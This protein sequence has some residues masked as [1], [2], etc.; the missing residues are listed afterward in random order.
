VVRQPILASLSIVAAL[1][2]APCGA[3]AAAQPIPLGGEIQLDLDSVDQ[4]PTCPL[5]AGRDDGRFLFLYG[6]PRTPTRTSV[7]A[8]AGASD[9]SLGPAVVLDYFGSDTGNGLVA[10]PGGYL[11][12]WSNRLGAIA[13]PFDVAGSP[14]GAPAAFGRWRNPFSL[15]PRPTGGFVATWTGSN[16]IGNAQLL[17]AQARPVRGPVRFASAVGRESIALAED[18]GYIVAWGT[19]IYDDNGVEVSDHGVLAQRFAPDGSRIGEPFQIV[20]PDHGPASW[21]ITIHNGV[22]AVLSAIDFDEGG[23]LVDLR[24]STFDLDGKRLSGPVTFTSSPT[25]AEWVP[26]AVAV[27]PAG[28]VLTLW[29]LDDPSGDSG[30]TVWAQLFDAGG[31]PRGPSFPVASTSAAAFGFMFCANAAWAGNAWVVTWMGSLD[32]AGGE[33]LATW[34][35]RFAPN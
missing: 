13:Q 8:R 16:G 32:G 1:C 14:A 2:Q 9:G 3:T 30:P 10:T 24:L 21:A 12:R 31:N 5:V 23:L 27:S 11:A 35:R 22:F 25:T 7:L 17:D 18:G 15:S 33:P 19:I 34:V 4:T 26:Q 28:D 20:Q 6:H 29:I